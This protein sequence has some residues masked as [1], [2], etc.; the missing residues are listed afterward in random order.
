MLA[1]LEEMTMPE[2]AAALGIP[3]NTAY[4]RLRLA[5]LDFQ[6]ALAAEGRP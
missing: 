2:V 6:R 4:S 1:L 3:L 5:R